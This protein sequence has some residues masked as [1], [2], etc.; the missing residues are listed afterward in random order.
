M[1]SKF[2]NVFRRNKKSKKNKKTVD[3]LNF[4]DIN[5]NDFSVEANNNDFIIEDSSKIV[6]RDIDVIL[7]HEKKEEEK[8]EEK[9]EE[10]PKVIKKDIKEILY[11]PSKIKSV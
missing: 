6:D 4:D 3:Q 10:K 8:V 11:N 2:K 7:P 9:V 1:N 5:K